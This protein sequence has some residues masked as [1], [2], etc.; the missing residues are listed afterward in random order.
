MAE[1]RWGQFTG[2]EVWRGIKGRSPE[3]A[4]AAAD[5]NRRGEAGQDGGFYVTES[6]PL[7]GGYAQR[8]QGDKNGILMRGRL[9]KDAKPSD[10]GLVPVHHVQW[11]DKNY[12]LGEAY[13]IDDQSK[14]YDYPPEHYNF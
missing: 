4:A 13:R 9:H 8:Y 3:E 12:T 1:T 5:A 2:P 14:G 7:A 6:V 11:D 10:L